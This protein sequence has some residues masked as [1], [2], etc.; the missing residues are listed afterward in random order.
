[1]HN[2]KRVEQITEQTNKR[3]TVLVS[4]RVQGVG[5]RAFVRRYAKNNAL[6]GYAENISDGRVEV[7][8]EGRKP[9]L[10]HLL[11]MLAKGPSHAKVSATDVTWG[12]AVGLE[13]FYIY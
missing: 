13:D 10:E 12:E 5:Y 3:L 6:S 9:D 8:V 4:G 2:E 11:L 1:M 7:V